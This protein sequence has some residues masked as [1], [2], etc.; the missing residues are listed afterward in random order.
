MKIKRTSKR[1]TVIGTT[2]FFKANKDKWFDLKDGKVIEIPDDDYLII[3]AAYGDSIQKVKNE[4]KKSSTEE[5][6]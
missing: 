6:G 5:K 4:T 1:I 3:K 2:V